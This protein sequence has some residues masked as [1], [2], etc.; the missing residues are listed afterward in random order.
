[1]SIDLAKI[2]DSLN[3]RHDR[4]LVAASRDGESQWR[5]FGVPD[6]ADAEVGSV[7]KGLT[8]LLYRDAIERGEITEDLTL[9]DA[10][11]RPEASW[12]GVT[13]GSLA[14]HRSG[15]PR[16]QPDGGERSQW[17]R[18]WRMWRR[19]ENPYGE[20]VEE[21]LDLAADAPLGKPRFSYSNLGFEL[22]GATVARQAGLTY[23]QALRTRVL[24]PLGMA[25][26]YVPS[27]PCDL[28]ADALAGRSRAGRLHEPW[29]GE[30]IGP[31]GGVR[32]TAP[33]LAALL[34]GLLE[35]TAPGVSALDPT[36]PAQGASRIGAAWLTIAV[37]GHE[38][39]WHNGMTGGF[40]SFVGVDRAAGVGIAMVSATASGFDAVGIK[41]LERL[42]K[43]E[44]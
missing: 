6:R 28:T 14:Q 7:S 3:A 1:M 36:H 19:G 24:E 20:S 25:G 17:T 35:G 40:A 42:R 9:G 44:V 11:D 12:A 43:G 32:A 39:T 30:A 26:S 21:L 5:A 10:L 23:A 16:L 31:A 13:L 8:G 15:L 33:D 18:T 27:K 22:L 34:T 4:V 37:K 29:V 2:R 38:V 41:A